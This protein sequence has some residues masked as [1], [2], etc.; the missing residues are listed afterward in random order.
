MSEPTY[1]SRRVRKL[2]P[3]LKLSV[4]NYLQHQEWENYLKPLSS[5]DAG[6][7]KSEWPQPEN[8]IETHCKK[9][10]ASNAIHRCFRDTELHFS[11]HRSNFE[12]I[13]QPSPQPTKT[14]TMGY[15]CDDLASDILTTRVKIEGLEAFS[16]R[17]PQLST[18]FYPSEPI[19]GPP[20]I[21]VQTTLD[22]AVND[23]HKHLRMVKLYKPLF[24][25][26]ATNA[27]ATEVADES[28]SGPLFMRTRVGW[29]TEL[30]RTY[31]VETGQL[32]RQVRNP[33]TGG[34]LSTRITVTEV[35]DRDNKTI[36]REFKTQTMWDLSKLS[37]QDPTSSLAEVLDTALNDEKDMHLDVNEPYRF[38]LAER[39]HQLA[40][41]TAHKDKDSPNTKT[42]PLHSLI[43]EENKS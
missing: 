42:A 21:S 17:H 28:H 2:P 31:W 6:G 20:K 26:M 9:L 14:L 8:V 35:R 19:R 3:E 16:T 41:L 22:A 39:I 12:R 29:V 7:M 40:F 38:Q 15:P 10:L 33:W 11:P 36:Q 34:T 1:L 30:P 32:S 43:V 25:S 27:T 5:T 13:E 18:V 37:A 4:M 23:L 24:H